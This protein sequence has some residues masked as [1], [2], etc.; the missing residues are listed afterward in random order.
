MLLHNVLLS[1]NQ[2]PPGVAVLAQEELIACRH[3]HQLG[4]LRQPASV[5]CQ[6]TSIK[7]LA[8]SS[9]I[10]MTALAKEED[11]LNQR[12]INHDPIFH[13]I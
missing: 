4:N 12:V 11:F 8:M 6:R 3:Y 10:V 13:L 1:T 9:L 5:T 7:L 2:M